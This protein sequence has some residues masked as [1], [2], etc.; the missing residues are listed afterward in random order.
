[1]ADTGLNVMRGRG[2]GQENTGLHYLIILFK[3]KKFCLTVPPL[4]PLQNN[5]SNHQLHKIEIFLSHNQAFVTGLDT[6]KK[7]ELLVNMLCMGRGSLDFAR[8]LIGAGGNPPATPGP[9]P[10]WCKCGCC[11]LMET[12]TENKCCDR[13]NCVTK[14]HSFSNICLDRD[15]LEVCIKSR[16]DF[17]SDEFDFSMESFRKAGYRQFVMWRFGKLGHGNRRVVPSCVIWAIRDSF[18]SAIGRYM[19]FRSS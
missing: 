12:E 17:R 2:F 16:C 11:R 5:F 13:V 15:I 14:M 4:D 9:S 8:N 7:D 19:G 18:P 6:T 10:E 1:M 3:K